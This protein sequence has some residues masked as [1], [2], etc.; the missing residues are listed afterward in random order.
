M[1]HGCIVLGDQH[2]YGRLTSGAI[3]ISNAEDIDVT[4]LRSASSANICLTSLEV[5]W[6]S[7]SAGDEAGDGEDGGE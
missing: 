2:S 1:F 6:S 3:K 4:A 7:K 5:G